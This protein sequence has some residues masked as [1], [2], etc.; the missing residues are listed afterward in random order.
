MAEPAR[1]A[2]PA[3]WEPVVPLERCFDAH[4]GLEVTS[5][6]VAGRGRVEGRVRIRDVLLDSAGEVRSAIFMAIAEALASRGSALAVMPRGQLAM[7]L[8]NDTHV[9]AGVSSG[10]LHATAAVISRG[11]DAWVW[12]VQV[13][14]DD[15]RPCAFSR[16]TVAIRSPRAGA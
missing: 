12:T 6:D 14:D 13:T 5:D 4:Y 9:L 15:G 2:L 3:G 16:V 11:A 8:S 7:G 10:T 1:T